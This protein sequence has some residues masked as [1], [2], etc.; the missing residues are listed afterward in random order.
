VSEV[1]KGT[2]AKLAERRRALELRAEGAAAR[3][4]RA[5][6]LV[7]AAEAAR[8][9][10]EDLRA[11]VPVLRELI[12]RQEEL[13][14]KLAEAAPLQKA[15]AEAVVPGMFYYLLTAAIGVTLMGFLI[16]AYPEMRVHFIAGMGVLFVGFVAFYLIRMQRFRSTTGALQDRLGQLATEAEAMVQ[17]IGEREEVLRASGLALVTDGYLEYKPALAEL[18]AGRTERLSEVLGIASLEREAARAE[19]ELR[20]AD[21]ELAQVQAGGGG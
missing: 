6:A 3:L 11:H 5:R 17:A 13:E 9:R 4:R 14:A 19:G 8:V 12:E 2:R 15:I 10:G 18:E 16:I 1:E 20:R 21:E 7:E